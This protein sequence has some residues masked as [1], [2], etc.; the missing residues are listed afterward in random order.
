MFN[1][2]RL[3]TLEN[4]L[5]ELK[6]KRD[7][8]TTVSL[9][10][11]TPYKSS[12]EI[13]KNL[14]LSAVYCAVNRI[15]DSLAVLD[16]K[17]YQIDDKGFKKEFTENPL[18]DLLNYEPNKYQGKSD[19]WKIGALNL[20]NNGNFYTYIERDK[21]FNPI[22]L[23]LLKPNGVSVIYI[24]GQ[25]KYKV[26]GKEGLID[27]S[28]I[29]HVINF[30]DA[31][32][33]EIGIS[34]IQYA[35]QS[36]ESVYNGEILASESL[37]NGSMSNVYIQAEGQLNEKQV[38][39]IQNRWRETFNQSTGQK[40]IPIVPPT[41]TI[42]NL[43]ISAKDAQLLESRAY[44]LTEIAR[45]YN[46]HPALL[47]DNTK[48]LSGTVEA[49]QIEY[50]NTTLQP[51]MQK[52]IN[53]FSRKLILPKDRHRLVLDYDTTDL[54]KMDS[55]AMASYYTTM[56]ANGFYSAN[57]VRKKIGQPWAEGG[58]E[59]YITVQQQN[60]KY[61]VVINKEKDNN[62]KENS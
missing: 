40:N 5:K 55:A 35:R 37:K 30:P 42:H 16:L 46:I 21:N 51:I 60:L 44:G 32:N 52:I 29:I 43:A 48:Q 54:I 28:N 9:P 26:V 2:N 62:L 58:D 23:E 11:G 13:N 12:F 57:D 31:D 22:S 15:S 49:M 7:I 61:P 53:A 10:I 20:L 36:L 47:F 25:K 8:F 41:M 39:D 24:D 14:T 6:D 33:P 56:T 50:L 18:N 1:N 59:V 19:Y 17:L 38:G 3:R 45:W 27:D 34:T 4:E